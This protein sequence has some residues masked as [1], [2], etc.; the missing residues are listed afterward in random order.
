MRDRQYEKKEGGRVGRRLT[1]MR[2]DRVIIVLRRQSWDWTGSEK[3]RQRERESNSVSS[4][5]P[6][7]LACLCTI[8]AECGR[9]GKGSG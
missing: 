2:D 4:S 5:I 3:G 6:F 1:R 9:S 7:D 8:G